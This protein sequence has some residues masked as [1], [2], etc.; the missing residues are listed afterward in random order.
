MSVSTTSLVLSLLGLRSGAKKSCRTLS[1]G[2][3]IHFFMPYNEN[4]S[5][6][7]I[8]NVLPSIPP[9][10]YSLLTGHC[11]W[12]SSRLLDPLFVPSDSRTKQRQTVQSRPN[13]SPVRI[14]LL[15]V[16]LSLIF[17][18]QTRSRNAEPLPVLISFTWVAFI[19]QAAI[20]GHAV[21]QSNNLITEGGVA[22]YWGQSVWLVLGSAFVHFGWG[23]E[24]VRWR[25]ALL[26]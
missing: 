3:S 7:I 8:A 14:R 11:L 9:H 12:S 19:A 6:T 10:C 24:A 25:A 1:F 18:L 15:H 17:A 20:V 5:R 26:K 23:Y 22:V 2:C 13:P 4:G 21:S 16:S